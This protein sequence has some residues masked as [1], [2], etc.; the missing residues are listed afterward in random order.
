MEAGA[1]LGPRPAR[2]GTSSTRTSGTSTN[3]IPNGSAA[4]I[5]LIEDRWAIPLREAIYSAGGF[6]LADAWVHPTDLIAIGL[7]A[8]EEAATH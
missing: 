7:L 4:A 1:V 5:A 8:K 6:H 3:A 2:T